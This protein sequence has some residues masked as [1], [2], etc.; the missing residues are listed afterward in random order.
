M[1][2][3]GAAGRVKGATKTRNLLLVMTDGLRWQEVF[4]GAD[5][6]LMDKTARAENPDELKKETPATTL[7]PIGA[8]YFFRSYGR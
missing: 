1:G 5:S 2:A 3:L 7:P 4:G 8:L 6:A